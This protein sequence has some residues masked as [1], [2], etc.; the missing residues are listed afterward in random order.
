MRG[1]DR[2]W[3]RR[4]E[5]AQRIVDRTIRDLPDD[6]RRHAESLTLALEGVPSKALKDEGLAPDLLGLFSGP[7]LRDPLDNDL[8]EPSVTLFLD[9][10]WEFADREWEVFEEEIRT[11]FLHELGHYLGLDEDGLAERDLD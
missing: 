3:Q 9:N 10:L 11:T 2:Q 6:V 4:V 5:T 7:S 1:A 8:S